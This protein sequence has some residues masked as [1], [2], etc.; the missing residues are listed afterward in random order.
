VNEVQVKL[1]A[2]TALVEAARA[3][4]MSASCVVNRSELLGLLNEVAALLPHEL[5]QAQEVLGDKR[6]VL[7]QGRAEARR[8]VERARAERRRLL[9]ATRV[10][11]EAERE[12]ARLLGQARAEAE[13][14][15]QEAEDYVDTKLATFEIVLTKTLAAVARG[16]EKLSGR[17]ELDELGE[18]GTFLD[19]PRKDGVP[20][21]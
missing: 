2:M 14:I 4:P 6:G 7:E 10:H 15:R 19:D 1:G 11:T 5:E 16:R 17:H 3:M 8:I 21:T 18:S 13:L 9:S 12:A 20:G